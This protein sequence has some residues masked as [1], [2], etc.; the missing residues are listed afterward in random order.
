MDGH[1]RAETVADE[2]GAVDPFAIEQDQQ[3]FAPL[4]QAKPSARERIAVAAQVET[5]NVEVFLEGRVFDELRPAGQVA[6]QSVQQDHH[7]VPRAA[8]RPPAIV[9]DHAVTQRQTRGRFAGQGRGECVQGVHRRVL[10]S[11]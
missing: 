11:I 4:A 1:L 5:Q 10:V 7:P 8:G 6:G 3:I 2:D 9:Q